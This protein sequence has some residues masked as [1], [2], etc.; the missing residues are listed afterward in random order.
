[1][2]FES[3]DKAYRAIA[4]ELLLS[5]ADVCADTL[6]LRNYSFTL[7]DPLKNIAYCRRIS[8]AY[9]VAEL[10][11]YFAGRNDVAFI[12]KFASLWERIT[13]DG[14]TNNSA[15]GY[16]LQAKYM[17]NQIETIV[18]L[19]RKDATSRRAVLNLNVPNAHVL[20][21]KDEPCTIALQFLIRHNR[22]HCTAI[23][24]SNDLWFGTPYDVIY[25][26]AI[27][28]FIARELGVSLGEYTHI[29]VSLH[30]YLR[31]LERLRDV[32]QNTDTD[33]TT[34]RLFPLLQQLQEVVAWVDSHP[35]D[36]IKDDFYQYAI[37]KG[38]IESYEH[39]NN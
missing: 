18:R 12:S 8:Y 15:Y 27:Q 11:W 14:Y 31:Y 20:E 17:F 21:T 34:I 30:V 29:A 3:M 28:A 24:R 13:D 16:I 33:N 6:E 19:L 38:I 35:K 2:K 39:T 1:M 32:V 37:S 4:A 36:G 5:H 23:M 22:L 9:A 10:A 7:K 25:F 26:T